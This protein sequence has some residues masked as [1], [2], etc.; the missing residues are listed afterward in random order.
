MKLDDILPIEKDRKDKDKWNKIYL[1]KGSPLSGIYEWGAWLVATVTYT[2]EIYEKTKEK[3]PIS[4]LR[5]N[6]KNGDTFA[7]GGFPETSLT[8]YIPAHKDVD[9]L[10]E[11]TIITINLPESFN[12]KTYEQLLEEFNQW[13]NSLPTEKQKKDINTNI[14][15]FAQ[16]SNGG[17]ISQIVNYS[18]EDHTPMENIEF[19]QRLKNTVLS[20]L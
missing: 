18:I 8:K 14:P 1:F 17:L 4:I 9:V 12:D 2:K 19:I 16:N 13:K 7:K 5:K 20:I 11:Y 6:M 10:N 3:K 15:S